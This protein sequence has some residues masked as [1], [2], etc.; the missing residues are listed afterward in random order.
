MDCPR[1]GKYVARGRFIKKNTKTLGNT[2]VIYDAFCPYCGAEFGRMFWGELIPSAELEA[3]LLKRA[4]AE[5]QTGTMKEAPLE[6]AQDTEVIRVGERLT[7]ICPH[8]GQELPGGLETLPVKRSGDRRRG[9]DR[10]NP[11]RNRRKN[12]LRWTGYERRVGERRQRDDRRQ[13][14]RRSAESPEAKPPEVIWEDK[15]TNQDRRQQKKFVLYDRLKPGDRR[16]GG[17][18]KPRKDW[19]G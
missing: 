11:I 10:R 12:R 18:F 17:V 14:D 7:Y 9:K 15:R 13:G 3:V 2:D 8:C 1:C 16:D 19:N 6:D 5:Q 4:E